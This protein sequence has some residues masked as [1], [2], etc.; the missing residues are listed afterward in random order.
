MLEFIL[1]N[2]AML[3][4]GVVLYLLAHSLPRVGERDTGPKGVLERWVTSEFPERLDGV[5]NNF[6]GKFLRRLR[7]ILLK[8]DNAVSE[9]LK[10]FKTGNGNG[11]SLDFKE[12]M[13]D[14]EGAQEKHEDE[15]RKRSN[16][17]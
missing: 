14:K 9:S 8:F 17:K 10:R 4:A 6:A 7:V 13:V 11:K 12:I 15:N 1:A 16:R 3:S 5:F 2:I